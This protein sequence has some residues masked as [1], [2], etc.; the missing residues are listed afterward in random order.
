[1]R[2]C[3]QDEWMGARTKRRSL[4]QYSCDTDVSHLI[5]E[6]FSMKIV[7]SHTIPYNTP[8]GYS[9]SIYILPLALVSF[10]ILYSLPLL[11]L[12][13]LSSLLLSLSLSL[14]YSSISSPLS[15]SFSLF[16][17]FSIL[18]PFNPSLFLS[19][20]LPLLLLLSPLSSLPPSFSSPLSPRSPLLLSPSLPLVSLL[21]PLSDYSLSAL[22]VGACSAYYFS[23]C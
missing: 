8:N 12:S 4:A 16:F 7:A 20:L 22:C 23:E 18:S 21:S 14:L 6:V 10:L 19:L 17:L 3:T 13:L 9:A 2:L 1:M 11:F 5:Y 15:L